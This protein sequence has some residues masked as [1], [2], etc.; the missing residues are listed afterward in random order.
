MPSPLPPRSV[1]STWRHRGCLLGCHGFQA[2]WGKDDTSVLKCPFWL[3]SRG[4]ILSGW[5]SESFTL[6]PAEGLVILKQRNGGKTLSPAVFAAL[7]THYPLPPLPCPILLVYICNSWFLKN[8]GKG[9]QRCLPCEDRW[10]KQILPP[11]YLPHP[12][13]RVAKTQG[14]LSL[15]PFL[16][17]A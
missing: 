2:W 9:L 13:V 5:R 10:V 4:Q 11:T 7:L 17:L 3:S 14:H 6:L 1:I 12:P 16:R 15:L 8:K